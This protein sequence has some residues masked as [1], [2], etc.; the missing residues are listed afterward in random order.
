MSPSSKETRL[1]PPCSS[2]PSAPPRAHLR[3]RPCPANGFPG[4]PV[5]WLTVAALTAGP[6]PAK[7]ELWLC[8][9]P[10][11][12]VVYFSEGGGVISVQELRTE[13]GFKNC[14]TG[15]LCY[16]FLYRREDI[17]R[18]IAAN[19]TTMAFEVIR[20]EVKAGNCACQ[21]RN[22]SGGCCL[23]DVRQAIEEVT[24]NATP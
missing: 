15:L 24:R 23:S 20:R 10:A 19:G 7:Q 12:P 1:N 6:V 13:P 3:S 18:E 21:V 11:C 9:D 22:P 16:C 4:K 17:V 5:G 8:R 2:P 14:T